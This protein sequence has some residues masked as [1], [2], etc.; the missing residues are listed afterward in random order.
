MNRCKDEYIVLL[1][2]I[3]KMFCCKSDNACNYTAPAKRPK[4]LI[5]PILIRVEVVRCLKMKIKKAFAAI[6]YSSIPF[7]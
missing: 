2:R 1:I 7:H 6:K 5:W 4:E 3:W